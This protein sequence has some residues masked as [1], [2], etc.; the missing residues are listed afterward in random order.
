MEQQTSLYKQSQ[1]KELR[2]HHLLMARM[3][4]TGNFRPKQLAAITGMTPDYISKIRHG[5]LMQKEIGGLKEEIRRE[6]VDVVKKMA[7]I[8]SKAVDTLEGLMDDELTPPAVRRAASVNILDRAGYAPVRKIE[9]R[10]MHA[11]LTKEDVEEIKQRAKLEGARRGSL[12][13]NVEASVTEDASSS[14][15]TPSSTQQEVEGKGGVHIY[16]RE[17]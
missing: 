15:N 3:I 5:E 8:S 14:P 2:E 4:A 7:E 11:H 12:V 16:E 10:H 17:D 1:L 6:T 13:V 9:A